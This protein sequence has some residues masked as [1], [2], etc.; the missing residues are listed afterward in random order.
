MD[1]LSPDF[2]AGGSKKLGCLMQEHSKSD[3][4]SEGREEGD[5]KDLKF[6][7]KYRCPALLLD[8][9]SKPCPP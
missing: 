8:L 3:I 1:S 6:F 2:I 9:S 5:K 4:F 7:H